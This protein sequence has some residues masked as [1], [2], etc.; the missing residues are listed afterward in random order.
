MFLNIARYKKNL[1]D[2][3]LT[4]SFIAYTSKLSHSFKIGIIHDTFNIV[5]KNGKVE[6]CLFVFRVPVS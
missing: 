3:F 6:I 5:R 4:G 1:F 2:D